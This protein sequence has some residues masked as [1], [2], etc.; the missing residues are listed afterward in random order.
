VSNR[1]TLLLSKLGVRLSILLMLTSVS[2]AE[3]PAFNASV[4]YDLL[5]RQCDF[6]PR[7]PGSFGHQKCLEWMV[8]YFRSLGLIPIEQKFDIIDPRS[9]VKLHLTNII[10][11]IGLGETPP[12]MLCAHWD[13]RSVADRDRDPKLRDQPISGANDGASGVAVLMEIARVLVADPPSRPVLIALWD[14]E[15]IGREN[16]PDEYAAG[17]RY[18]ARHQ[19]PEPPAEAILLDMVGDSDLRFP[20]E[21]FSERYSPAL[22]SDIWQIAEQIG[23]SAFTDEQ[24]PAVEDDHVPLIRAGIPSIDIID[25]DYPYW[26]TQQDTPDKCSPESLGQTGRVLLAYIYR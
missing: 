20:V 23:V 14:G 15:D 2:Y 3:T 22:R 6:G 8:A 24:G 17:S 1:K 7:N 4:S 21:W 10:V 16:H 18:W 13:T 11:P 5:K 19:T 12:V 25:F 9:G 26:H